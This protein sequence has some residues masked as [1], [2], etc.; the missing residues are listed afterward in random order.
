MKYLP[1][2]TY[3]GYSFFKSSIKIDE[4]VKE[5]KNRGYK[6]L[7][8]CDYKNMYAF[9]IFNKVCKS[10]DIIP[11]FG[12]SISFKEIDISFIIKNEEGYLNLI[13]ISNLINKNKEL[14]VYDIPSFE[15]LI[16]IIKSSSNSL[17][18]IDDSRISKLLKITSIF[19]EVYLG[20]ENEKEDLHIDLLREFLKDKI[21]LI[22][23][24]IIRHLKKEEAISL[25]LLKCIESN[26]LFNKDE[27]INDYHFLNDQE[28]ENIYLEDEIRN[29][30]K[31]VKE[32][33]FEFIKKRGQLLNYSKEINSSLNSKELLKEYLLKGLKDKNIDLYLN[34]KYRDRLNYEYL[35][36]TKMGFEDYFLI[37]QDYVNYAKKS[38]II[39]GPGRGSAAGSLVAYL[40]NITN[41][42]PLK[43]NLL[44]ERFLN[45]ERNTM[46]DID[47]DYQDI[48]RE[49][50]IKYLENKYS[51]NKVAHVIAFQNIKAKQALRDITRIL[52]YDTSFADKLSKAIP[53]NF[54]LKDGSS[55]FT[56]L[57]AYNNIDSFKNIVDSSKDFQIIYEYSRKIEGLPR[58]STLHAAGII[59]SNTS[60]F[61]CLPINYINEN[62]IVSQYEKDYLEDQGFLKFDLLGL[63]NLTTIA[64][65]LSLINKSNNLNTEFENLPIDDPKIYSLINNNLLMGLFQID[66]SAGRIATMQIKPNKF[67]EIVDTISL[68]R[69]GPIKYIKN[70]VLRKNNKEK[71]NYPS[72]DLIPILSSTY[73]IIIYQEQIMMIARIFAGFSYSE[74]DLFR[75]AISKKHKDDILKM[76]EKFI[77]GSILKGHDENLSLK[78][79]NAILKFANYGFNKSHAVSYAMIT[80]KMAYL[81]SNY[82]LEFYSSILTMEFSSSSNKILK[83]I[84]EIKKMGIKILNPSLNESF[85]YFIPYNGSILFPFTSIKNIS[86]ALI[87]RIIKE[88]E[89]NGLYKDIFDFLYRINKGE[90]LLNESQLSL[91]I[92]AG[93]F[94]SFI[95]NRKALKQ[96]VQKLIS[97]IEYR[98]TLEGVLKDNL[99]NPAID[100][101]VND[102][103]IERINNEV[104]VLNLAIS[105]NL[106]NHVKI[107]NNIKNKIIEIN[108]LIINQTSLILGIIKSLKTITIKN[109]KLQ[110]KLMCFMSIEDNNSELELTLFPET[111]SKYQ[112]LLILGKLLL[113][114]GKLEN[115]NDKNSFIVYEINEV[116]INE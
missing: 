92:D 40:L 90:K 31:I 10:N 37:V 115:R 5:A 62:E 96:N 30:N 113:I 70:Y 2:N 69:P 3:S 46:P 71:I 67:I 52:N 29:L 55:S 84:S 80:A 43:Y 98:E 109:G 36:I 20:L 95:N 7:G 47:T 79:F 11:I 105:D 68:A 15:G 104:K 18:K 27:E 63:S 78:I 44:F 77:K 57:D 60:L 22:A 49:E 102:D 75:R 97:S 65:T 39:V 19:K 85:N 21:T 12:V 32:I 58:Q 76:K 111:Y 94:D 48:R 99:I 73:G 101:N 33:N 116:K 114:K 107:D 4:Y 56:L 83:Y 34:K 74:A 53:D 14:S 45:P 93:V 38:N 41:V 25:N 61:E 35:T 64:L 103:P 82:P 54:K 51:N 42:D 112:E 87:N 8:L 108:N 23:F 9:P 50:V 6:Y 28:I 17:S 100:L 13:K 91:L 110:G 26:H 72:K 86:N 88:R 66:A 16:A 24:P 1:L 89:E 81:K 59:I 106:L